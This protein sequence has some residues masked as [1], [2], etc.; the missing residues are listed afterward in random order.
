MLQEMNKSDVH[1]IISYLKK[2]VTDH[3]KNTSV[4]VQSYNDYWLSF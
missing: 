1:F 2:L 3:Y 4:L